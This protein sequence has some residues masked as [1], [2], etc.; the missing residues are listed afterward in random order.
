[1]QGTYNIHVFKTGNRFFL[2]PQLSSNDD[3]E[4]MMDCACLYRLD[5]KTMEYIE[6]IESVRRHEI[7]GYVISWMFENGMEQVRG[8]SFSDPILSDSEKEYI[9][10]Q[11]K[12][13]HYEL[14]D[15]N[16]RLQH[17]HKFAQESSN[18]DQMITT[19]NAHLLYKHRIEQYSPKAT[20]SDLDWLREICQT[21][22]C[23]NIKKYE[24]VISRLTAVYKQYV[25][26]MEEDDREVILVPI[27]AYF[28]AP[29]L[30]FDAYKQALQDDVM[31]ASYELM[32]YTL[33][34][35]VVDFKFE[36][37]DVDFKLEEM[38][39]WFTCQTMKMER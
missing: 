18:L 8:G 38:K 1:M 12:Y 15:N 33:Q 7:D 28:E 27:K 22:V 5:Y 30:Y 32:I 23:V 34:N 9:S 39:I 13:A 10:R 35:R 21:G 31:F 4:T 16:E 14:N 6:K 17:L 25:E 26:W 19:H 37:E 24:N 11:I 29:R 20:I 36:I 3:N 2:Y